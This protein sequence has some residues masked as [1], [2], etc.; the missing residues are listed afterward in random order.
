ML[1]LSVKLRQELGRQNKQ[2]RK[3]G[4]IPAILYGRKVKNIPLLVKEHNFEKVYQVAGE[5]TLIK[6]KIQG[7]DKDKERVV[8]IHDTAI[9]PVSDHFIHAD[10][11]QVKMDEV[12]K[13]EVALNFVGISEAVE[14]EG[15]VLIKSIQQVEIEALPQ[16]LPHEIE[17]DISSLKTFDD[18]IY[19]KDLKIPDKAKLAAN[20]EDLIASVIPPRTKAELEQLEEAP[21]E[22]VDEVEVEEKGKTEQGVEGE[23]QESKPAEDAAPADKQESASKEGGNE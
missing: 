4:F 13:V 1:E 19:V 14:T 15:G 21:V 20:P 8:L 11:Y 5:S 23:E 18:N 9:D 10:F 22:S 6:L 3:Q 12:I 16:D 2:V 7:G 17:V